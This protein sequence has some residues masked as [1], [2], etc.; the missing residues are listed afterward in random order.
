V[1]AFERASGR[2]LAHEFGPRRPGDVPAYWGDPSRAEA[3]LGWRAQRGLDQ[4][5]A[6]SWRWQQGNPNGYDTPPAHG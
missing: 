2:A 5:C 3:T 4:M 1:H 6:D